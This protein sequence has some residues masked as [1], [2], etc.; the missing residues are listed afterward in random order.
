VLLPQL[1]HFSIDSLVRNFN[2]FLNQVN[3]VEFDVLDRFPA[4]IGRVIA[5]RSESFDEEVS[6][7]EQLQKR[8]THIMTIRR[9]PV[10]TTVF[11][12]ILDSFDFN[13]IKLDYCSI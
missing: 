7:I 6:L 13:S 10:S 1:R 4:R 2:L 9:L 11:L 3:V 5:K 12:L 8:V